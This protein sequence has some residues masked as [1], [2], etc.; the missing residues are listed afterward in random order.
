MIIRLTIKNSFL[1]L[2]VYFL[3]KDKVMEL[4]KEKILKEGKVFPGNI[5]K[6]DNFLNHLV[7]TDLMYQIG[8]EFAGIF[9]GEKITKILTIEASGIAIGCFAAHE[10]KVPLLYAKKGVRKNQSEVYT[11]KVMSYTHGKVYDI[12]VS[13]EYLNADDSILIIDDFLASGEALKGLI[14]LINQA[15][16]KLVG[17]GIVIEKA[18][19][20]G[21]KLLREEGVR[22]ESLAKIVKMTDNEVI[23]A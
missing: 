10:M 7:D 14:D 22:I 8:K 23:F 17:C 15:G 2:E 20:D 6:V 1:I 5:L 18:F 13:K 3:R 21:G 9:S 4:L 19:Q 12:S 11:S 16:A